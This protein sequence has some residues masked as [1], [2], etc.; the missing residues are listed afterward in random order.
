MI[1]PADF[2][3]RL[4][5]GGE[6]TNSRRAIGNLSALCLAHLP[7]RHKIEIVDVHKEPGRALADRVFLV[8]SLVILEPPPV[9]RIIGTLS[10]AEAVLDNLGLAP[11][12]GDVAA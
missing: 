11:Q 1:R 12:P 9:R 2:S 3:F 4:Y 5:V 10:D 6:T 7:G 8:P